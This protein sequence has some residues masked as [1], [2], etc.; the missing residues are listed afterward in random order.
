MR[1][2][3]NLASSNCTKNTDFE[4]KKSTTALGK[5]QL[6]DVK[7]KRDSMHKL[8]KKQVSFA[9]DVEAADVDSDIDG[10]EDVNFVSGSGFQNE[11]SG[12]QSEYK[13]SLGN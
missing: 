4:R 3:D 1:L 5:E 11:R 9:E 7:A 6:N 13:N 2:I 10:E 12:N 8:L